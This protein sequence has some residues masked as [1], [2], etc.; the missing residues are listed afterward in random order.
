MMFRAKHITA[1][2]AAAL[3]GFSTVAFVPVS[4]VAAKASPKLQAL[5]D[6]QAGRET[7]EQK[8]LQDLKSQNEEQKDLGRQFGDLTQEQ[9]DLARQLEDKAKEFDDQASALIQNLQDVAQNA[10]GFQGQDFENNLRPLQDQLD[11]LQELGDQLGNIAEQA[12]QEGVRQFTFNGAVFFSTKVVLIHTGTL[13]EFTIIQEG[14]NGLGEELKERLLDQAKSV[15]DLRNKGAE[16]NNGPK[17]DELNKL[18]Q[19]R[20]NEE[21]RQDEIKQIEGLEEARANGDNVLAALG[22]RIKNPEQGEVGQFANDPDAQKRVQDL[23]QGLAGAGPRLN[24]IAEEEAK[25]DEQIEQLNQQIGPLDDQINQLDNLL[26]DQEDLDEDVRELDELLADVNKGLENLK[27]LEDISP[28]ER[29]KVLEEGRQFIEKVKAE[30]Q[31]LLD[32]REKQKDLTPQE[33]ENIKAELARLN[34][35]REGL[36][37]Q[38]GELFDQRGELVKERNV[39]AGLQAELAFLIRNGAP[40]HNDKIAARTSDV[41]NFVDGRS[42]GEGVLAQNTSDGSDGSGEFR[43]PTSDPLSPS[44]F[45]FDSTQGNSES[46]LGLSGNT[47]GGNISL[48]PCPAGSNALPVG[49]LVSNTAFCFNT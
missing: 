46:T 15:E 5:I 12:R 28:E 2:V 47:G 31:G 44:Q 20:E 9:K 29:A 17:Q 34:D 39:I 8:R 35:E 42:D 1:T 32:A 45:G 23:A 13:V 6:G 48:I 36:D 30:K 4:E 38:R 19:L 18:D 27:N 26:R 10:D 40:L 24:E 3:I 22:D 43:A 41:D 14:D 7:S 33:I 11:K 25:L 16:F 21:A 49:T 37:N